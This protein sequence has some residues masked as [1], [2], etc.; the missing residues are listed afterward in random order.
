MSVVYWI[1]EVVA[2]KSRCGCRGRRE[3]RRGSSKRFALYHAKE[4]DRGGFIDYTP[5]LGSTMTNRAKL[6][7]T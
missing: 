5:Q 3:C 6:F 2:G 4:T 7:A 1:I